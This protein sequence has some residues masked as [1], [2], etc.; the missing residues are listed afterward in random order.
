MLLEHGAEV[1]AQ[2]QRDATPWNYAGKVKDAGKKAAVLEVLSEYSLHA[3]ANAGNP[4]RVRVLITE[5]HDVNAKGGQR[6]ETPAHLAA[7]GGHGEAL[8]L[9]VA[10]GADV[11]GKDKVSRSASGSVQHILCCRRGCECV[12]LGLAGV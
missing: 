2:D 4:E 1:N 11:N 5:G 8:K 7:K 3:A 10:A 12:A 6:G 9:V